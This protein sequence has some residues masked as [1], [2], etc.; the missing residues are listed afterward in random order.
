MLGFRTRHILHPQAGSPAEVSLKGQLQISIWVFFS[1]PVNQQG[2]LSLRLD[3]ESG[4]KGSISNPVKIFLVFKK[5]SEDFKNA[6]E[7]L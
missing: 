7:H 1:I 6:K 5:G 3:G 4:G 2:S